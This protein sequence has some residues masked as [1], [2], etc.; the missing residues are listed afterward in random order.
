MI[1]IR[2]NETKD[3]LNVYYEYQHKTITDEKDIKIRLKCLLEAIVNLSRA[4]FHGFI[5]VLEEASKKQDAGIFET[6]NKEASI[7]THKVHAK[8]AYDLAMAYAKCVIDPF[9]GL[10]SLCAA[11]GISFVAKIF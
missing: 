5:V 7:F 2:F 11:K 1:N 10:S 8:S 4:I 6:F 3:I 9:N